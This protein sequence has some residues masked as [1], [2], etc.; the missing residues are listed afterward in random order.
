MF[1]VSKWHSL[2]FDCR[3]SSHITLYATGLI[4]KVAS[5]G[6]FSV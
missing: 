5:A 6:Y 3:Q 4:E 1:H 2:A